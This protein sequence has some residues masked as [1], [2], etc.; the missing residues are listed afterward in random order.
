MFE[1][2]AESR[3]SCILNGNGGLF[4]LNGIVAWSKFVGIVK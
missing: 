4:R 3:A 2:G 1:E